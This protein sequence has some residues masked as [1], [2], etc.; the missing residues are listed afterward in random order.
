M[1]R[2]SILNVS[3]PTIPT[4]IPPPRA[5]ARKIGPQDCVDQV[6]SVTKTS[7]GQPCFVTHPWLSTLS[8]ISRNARIAAGM[9][10]SF[11]AMR[12]KRKVDAAKSPARQ[13]SLCHLPSAMFQRQKGR[14]NFGNKRNIAIMKRGG[15]R[16]T[17]WN[18]HTPSSVSPTYKILLLRSHRP[19]AH[20]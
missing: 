20:G 4:P 2:H 8:Q 18:F 17:I 10:V 1:F 13:C 14:T 5:T 19:A 3:C 11:L 7:E 9:C 6:G 16:P 15:K 12:A